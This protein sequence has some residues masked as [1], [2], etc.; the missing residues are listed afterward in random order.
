MSISFCDEVVSTKVGR[1]IVDVC[2]GL[3]FNNCLEGQKPLTGFLP[4]FTVS[5]KFALKAHVQTF[6][7][8]FQNDSY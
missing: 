6:V 3:A 7:L 5:R 1:K 2:F 8:D 4:A